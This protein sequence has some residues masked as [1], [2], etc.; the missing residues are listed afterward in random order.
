MEEK[1]RDKHIERDR[2][3]L[4]SQDGKRKRELW[5]SD[6]NGERKIRERKKSQV[7]RKG[8]G[9]KREE[10]RDMRK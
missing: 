6:R 2:N 7:V 5:E 4:D 3:I 1:E 9:R 8:Q 10:N